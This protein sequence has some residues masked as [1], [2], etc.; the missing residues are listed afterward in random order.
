MGF[1][2]R[3]PFLL[4]FLFASSLLASTDE[5]LYF[6]G[7]DIDILTASEG[8]PEYPHLMPN[9]SE[10]YKDIDV[11]YTLGDFLSS[12]P[13]F[14]MEKGEGESTLYLRGIQ[15]GALI[16]YNGV[17]ITNDLTKNFNI[18]DG[19]LSLSGVNKIEV[20]RGAS[21]TLWGPDAFG[22][23]VNIVPKY[24]GDINGVKVSGNLN[25]G[26]DKSFWFNAGKKQANLEYSLNGYFGESNSYNHKGSTDANISTNL[27][28]KDFFSIDYLFVKNNRYFYYKHPD[29]NYKWD[30]ENDKRID[31]V[32]IELYRKNNDYYSG[33][34]GYFYKIDAELNDMIRNWVQN[35]KVYSLDYRFDKSL[36]GR[37][38][39]FSIGVGY[40]E[41]IISD[42][43]IN[44][45]GYPPDYA[46]AEESIFKPLT[47]IISTST[48]TKTFFSQYQH[49]FGKA[50]VLFSVRKDFHSF[51]GDYLNYNSSI[52]LKTSLRSSLKFSV[53]TAYRTPYASFLSDDRDP[54]P[55]KITSYSLEYAYKVTDNFNVSLTP[56]YNEVSNYVNEDPFG[57]ISQYG[58]FKTIGTEL[59]VSYKKGNFDTNF[60][61][62]FQNLWNDK[63]KYRTLDYIL[64]LPDGTN[65]YF[66]SNLEKTIHSGPRFF[67]NFLMNY[68]IGAK[69]EVYSR[70][71][72]S[73]SRKYDVL[74][75]GIFYKFHDAF[76]VDAGVRFQKIFGNF[77]AD[78]FVKD[79][80]DSR[81]SSMGKVN[82][83]DS[84]GRYFGLILSY[85]F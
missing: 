82:S 66:Y 47:Q 79:M 26:N 31:L 10:E 84:E 27:K 29:N 71:S 50:D 13:G 25:T 38:G 12:K 72:Y 34:S 4:M 53:G 18:V 17:P 33:L 74:P 56:F 59:N 75:S 62:T 6:L 7:T 22:G 19:E 9:I 43:N 42:S 48:R 45:R 28:I 44:N 32:K 80:F 63:E 52:M 68:R 77:D 24:G 14:F 5:S 36:F 69:A 51:Y 20:I 35:V 16:L 67:G 81:G 41:N 64:I 3:I 1:R 21:S 23:I 39:L 70:I 49:H 85:N 78:I 65:E 76:F 58:D 40:K 46:E 8:R 37:R 11:K 57:G 60:N 55:E 54:K 61:L 30:S 83:V 2:N 15:N 73:D